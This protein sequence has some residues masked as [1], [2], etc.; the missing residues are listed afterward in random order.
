VP[1]VSDEHLTARREQI[2]EGARRAFAKHGYESATV[3]RL[4]EEIGLSR[5]A[6]FHY[7]PDKWS[8]FF[9]LAV[10]DQTRWNTLIIERGIDDLARTIY[11]ENPDWLGVYLEL[12]RHIRTHP[13]LAEQLEQRMTEEELPS[14]KARLRELQEEGALRDDVPLDKLAEFVNVVLNGIVAQYA[15]GTELD[16]ESVLKLVHEGLDPRA[17]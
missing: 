7:F 17:K 13:E 11:A 4:E 9:E 14:G 6:I 16:V 5:G 8:L 2:L 3:A 15:S 1:K 12:A 10:R